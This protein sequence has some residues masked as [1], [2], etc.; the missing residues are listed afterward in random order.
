MQHILRATQI[1]QADKFEL[2]KSNLHS[3]ACVQYMGGRENGRG[4]ARKA[5]QCIEMSAVR[6]RQKSTKS[7]ASR[8]RN[9]FQIYKKMLHTFRAASK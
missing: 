2:L 6:V 9:L 8:D 7:Q 4:I 3:F 1:L 5:L